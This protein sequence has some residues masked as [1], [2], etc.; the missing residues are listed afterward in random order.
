MRILGLRA[1]RLRGDRCWRI[2]DKAGDAFALKYRI[3]Q[4]CF[5]RLGAAVIKMEVVFPGESHTAVDL[6]AAVAN[7]AG[8]IA[9]V[10]LRDRDRK[11]SVLRALIDG[12]A[13]V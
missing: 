2:D 9:R 8:S 11:F 1:C 6:N 3:A 5:R 10:H 12:P 7:G 13:G 4:D